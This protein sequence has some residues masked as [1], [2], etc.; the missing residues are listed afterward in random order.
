MRYEVKHL[1]RAFP[2]SLALKLFFHPNRLYPG[3]IAAMQVADG[4]LQGF[5]RD[6]RHTQVV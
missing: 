6:F 4:F 1:N 3:G 2:D 5:D